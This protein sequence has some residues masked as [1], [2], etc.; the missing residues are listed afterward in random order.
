[1][2]QALMNGVAGGFNAAVQL[3]GVGFG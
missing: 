1:M 3:D 2:I